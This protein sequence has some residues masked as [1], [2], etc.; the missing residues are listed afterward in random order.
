MLS[1]LLL[2][3][4]LAFLFFV[5]LASLALA[6]FPLHQKQIQHK[7]LTRQITVLMVIQ[8]SELNDRRSVTCG[9]CLAGVL[10]LGKHTTVVLLRYHCPTCCMAG[11]DCS[12][13]Q[14]ALLPIVVS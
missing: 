3:V 14:L 11:H 6:L 4:L 1:A 12:Q 2:L 13:A 9:L 7:M 8:Y 5:F 10:L